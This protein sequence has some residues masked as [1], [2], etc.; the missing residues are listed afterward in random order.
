ML[1]PTIPPPI[2]T[3]SAVSDIEALTQP[4]R[5]FFST[6]SI[7]KFL[8]LLNEIFQASNREENADER[9]APSWRGL[10][11]AYAY[12]GRG[13]ITGYCNWLRNPWRRRAPRNVFS[14]AGITYREQVAFCSRQRRRFR[15]DTI[16][17]D[18]TFQLQSVFQTRNHFGN[19]LSI[20]QKPAR[21]FESRE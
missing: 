14:D 1:A 10:F 7:T 9:A 5:G 2:M 15:I 21:R 11:S 18:D 13:S 19:R 16:G 3:T 4:S 20:Y 12:A 8:A 6:D 17:I